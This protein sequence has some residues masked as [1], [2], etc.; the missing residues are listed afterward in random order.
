MM[1]AKL[2][3]VASLP[4][5]PLLVASH[6]VLH[7]YVHNVE[8]LTLSA[9]LVPLGI[10]LGSVLAIY[11]LCRLALKADTSAGII[12]TSVAAA[13]LYYCHVYSFVDGTLLRGVEVNQTLAV[14]L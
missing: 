13:I 1:R 4:F 3:Q 8:L 2:Q 9:I 7:L 11:L 10:V 6:S 14:V 5:Y 12:A